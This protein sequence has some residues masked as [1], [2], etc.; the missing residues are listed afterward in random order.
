MNLDLIFKFGP[1][2][3]EPFTA[4][5][6]RAKRDWGDILDA[7]YHHPLCDILPPANG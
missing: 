3:G 6:P 2:H 1:A 5:K 7:F 4:F